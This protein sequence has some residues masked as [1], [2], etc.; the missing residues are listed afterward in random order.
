M[1]LDGDKMAA[2]R[3]R[4]AAS[5]AEQAERL[6]ALL[7]AGDLEGLRALAHSVAGRA[8]MFGFPELGEIARQADEADSA[9]LPERARVLLAAVRASLHAEG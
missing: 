8:G 9:A 6:P 5:L 2:L 1:S 4:F 7:E 3:E